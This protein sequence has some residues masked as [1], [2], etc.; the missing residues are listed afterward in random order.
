MAAFGG[1]EIQVT[2]EEL[3]A[4]ATSIQ[5]YVNDIKN[6]FENMKSQIER[7]RS[8]W[9][10]EAADAFIMFYQNNTETIESSVRNLLQIPTMLQDISGVYSQTET[11]LS[12]VGEALPGDII[13]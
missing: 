11:V 2:P 13:T 4:T 12:A 9:E 6:S 5:A 8:F 3:L 1:Y 10:G 7:S